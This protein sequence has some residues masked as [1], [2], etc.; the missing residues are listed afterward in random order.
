MQAYFQSGYMSGGAGYVMS[1]RA[2]DNLIKEGFRNGACK[3]DGGDEDVE[4]GKC[5]AV[6]VCFNLLHKHKIATV[7][8]IKRDG[9]MQNAISCDVL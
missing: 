1:A 3:S 5:L 8:R 7:P 2:L 9:I 4:I 6:H